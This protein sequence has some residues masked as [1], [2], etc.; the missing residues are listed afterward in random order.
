M[1]LKITFN[2][3]MKKL[4]FKP[5]YQDLDNLLKLCSDITRW[6]KDEI[7]LKFK[8][9]EGD[10]LSILTEDD[11]EYFIEQDKANRFKIIEIYQKNAISKSDIKNHQG[12][13]VNDV[14]KSG[15]NMHIKEPNTSYDNLLINL[16][17][18]LDDIKISHINP[19]MNDL[20][21]FTDAG[22]SSINSKQVHYAN[23]TI[24]EAQFD[25]LGLSHID[26]SFNKYSDGSQK[27]DFTSHVGIDSPNSGINLQN[28][29][30]QIENLTNK[31]KRFAK[32]CNYRLDEL[33]AG[34]IK[35]TNHLLCLASTVN[36]K[37]DTIESIQNKADESVV[38]DNVACDSCSMIP[39]VGK[40]YK[41]IECEDTDLCEQCE[42]KGTH[43]HEMLRI[44]KPLVETDLRE[45]LIKYTKT[46][47]IF[48]K[49][50]KSCKIKNMFG[51]KPENICFD[52]DSNWNNKST[53]INVFKKKSHMFDQFSQISDS[54]ISEIDNSISVDNR[55]NTI[56][57]SSFSLQP[58]LESA[59]AIGFDLPGHEQCGD[60]K[61]LKT[62]I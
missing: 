47:S 10:D 40:R 42:Q 27:T 37:L 38:H 17:N 33:E 26:N 51:R 4:R 59:I 46:P 25:E 57:K 62:I 52:E 41:C 49:I 11:L 23:I 58:D 14:I 9:I 19:K 54:N 56:K 29:L 55:N 48:T 21:T 18:T 24:K 30:H 50:K 1:F 15:N 61:T 22:V 44:S 43:T 53:T 60:R 35:L 6:P 12:F 28:L 5:E 39:I 20:S 16:D 8:D 36:K 31:F 13:I 7:T 32:V 3:E 2:D 45:K 34:H